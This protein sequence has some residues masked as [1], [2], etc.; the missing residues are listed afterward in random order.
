M[1]VKN[2][3]YE[4]KI[5]SSAEWDEIVKHAADLK[6]LYA[7]GMI[8]AITH[9]LHKNSMNELEVILTVTNSN[10]G[11]SVAR[12]YQSF[13]E[14]KGNDFLSEEIKAI[15]NI[16]LGYEEAEEIFFHD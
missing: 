5:S 1:Q 6:G 15:A 2:R 7:N 8:K 3:G 14:L 16:I 11:I 10:N 9:N 4:L 13:T 12:D